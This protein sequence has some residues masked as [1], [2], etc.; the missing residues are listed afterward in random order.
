MDQQ[1]GKTF[2][3]KDEMVPFFEKYMRK[4]NK[5]MTTGNCALF[6]KEDVENR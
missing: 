1:K 3:S 2:S 5:P 4:K 6:N